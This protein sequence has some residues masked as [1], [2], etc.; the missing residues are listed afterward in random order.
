M[1][2]TGLLLRRPY[3][4]AYA[5][6]RRFLVANRFETTATLIAALNALGVHSTRKPGQPWLAPNARLWERQFCEKNGIA[7]Q[8]AGWV[9]PRAPLRNCPSCAA[10]CYH[11]TLFQY[12]WAKLCPLHN[13]PIVTSC[14]GCKRPWPVPSEL[15]KRTCPH[16][17]AHV[18]L[19]TLVG[20]EGFSNNMDTHAFEPVWA[21]LKHYEINPQTTL[22]A[23]NAGI[24]QYEKHCSLRED[25]TEW[26]SLVAHRQPTLRSA[27]E[28]FGVPLSPVCERVY[29]VCQRPK[30]VNPRRS[31][32]TRWE[33][34]LSRQFDIALSAS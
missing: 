9:D 22:L 10:Q 28:A 17:S 5:A 27:F 30:E 8:S 14:P 19:V 16:C 32:E 20:N 4:S 25:H 23:E 34:R 26:P 24:N 21:A 18:S 11:S 2:N 13:I 31:L 33:R 6:Y 29:E 3:E 7:F 1:V 15:L 12:P